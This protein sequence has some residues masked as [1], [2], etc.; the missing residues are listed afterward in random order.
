MMLRDWRVRKTQARFDLSLDE[1]WRS[2][3]RKAG[4]R[5]DVGKAGSSRS[6]IDFHAGL[7]GPS[8]P[9]LKTFR[10]LSLERIPSLF[11]PWWPWRES[12]PGPIPSANFRRITNN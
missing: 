3:T 6:L 2:T 4:T 5:C 7:H 10:L 12:A 11:K 9:V 8:T 1:I